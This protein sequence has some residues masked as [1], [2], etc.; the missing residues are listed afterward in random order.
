MT[1]QSAGI[2][3][4]LYAQ[5]FVDKDL[6]RL[7]L[8]AVEARLDRTV[9]PGVPPET[10]LHLRLAFL[11]LKKWSSTLPPPSLEEK[12][13]FITTQAWLKRATAGSSSRILL[14]PETVS[15]SPRLFLLLELSLILLFPLYLLSRKSYV[16]CSSLVICISGDRLI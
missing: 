6:V 15:S 14:L 13:A 11:R 16:Y 7:D 1:L 8:G 10:R 4:V 2:N 9:A 3:I 12:E 5:S